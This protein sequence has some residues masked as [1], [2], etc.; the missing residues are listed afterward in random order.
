M[1]VIFYKIIEI[2]PP[3]GYE[4][5]N[6]TFTDEYPDLK[7]LLIAYAKNPD[8]FKDS[9]Y[10]NFLK[11]FVSTHYIE[12]GTKKLSQYPDGVTSGNLIKVST[13]GSVN[14]YD[15]QL[16]NVKS[17]KTWDEKITIGLR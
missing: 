2:V 1:T 14:I 7:S 15:N 4:G 10:Y 8:S 12:Y 5:S 3:D 16:I 17:E 9:D 11:N 6:L 13:G